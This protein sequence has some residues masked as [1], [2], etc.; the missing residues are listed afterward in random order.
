[1]RFTERDANSDGVRGGIHEKVLPGDLEAALATIGVIAGDG[2]GPEVVREGLAILDEVAGMDGLRPDLVEFDLGGERYLRTGAVLP[3][4]ALE[5]LRR[6]DAIYLGAVGHPGVAPGILEKG[7]LL[8]LRFAFHQ[9]I[10]LRPVR[11]FPGV[12]TPIKGKGPDDIDLVVVRENNEDLYVGAGG[13][14]YKGTPEEVAIQTSINTRAGVERCLRYAFGLARSRGKARAFPG[15]SAAERDLG[16]VG[17]V[18]MVAKTNVL[19]FAHDLW[20]R[21]FTEV[22]LDYPEIK[23]DYNHVD[24]CCMRMVV[25]PERYDVIATT[26]MFGDIITDLGAVLQGGMG[27]AASGNI[28]PDRKFPSMFEP[29]HGSAP[30][31]A[32]KG[33]ANPVAAILSLGMMLDHLGAPRGAEA[34]RRAVAKVLAAGTHRTPDL[35]GTAGTAEVGRAVLQALEG[36]SS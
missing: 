36:N 10:N 1:M 19:T 8:R 9:Y 22:S 20:M 32:G 27:L 5:D 21:A 25:A 34:V 4:A 23:A 24:A 16:L 33:V 17:Q 26:N 14:T 13:F 12:E 2:V 30:D 18:T 29:V 35:G 7:I 6:C 11:L 31:I 15:L 28:N 3:D